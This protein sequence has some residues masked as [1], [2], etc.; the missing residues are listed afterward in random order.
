MH[1]IRLLHSGIAALQT[2]EIRVEVGEHR[3]ELL[4]IKAGG[5]SFDKVKQRALDL[6]GRFQ[7]AFERTTLPEQ[8]DFAR[9]DRFLCAARRRM[10]D[11]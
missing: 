9:V 6:D 7:E 5:L 8:P 1:L 2:G 3:E 11:A 4:E 10:V